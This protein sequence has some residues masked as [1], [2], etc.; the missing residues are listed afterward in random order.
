[1]ANHRGDPTEPLEKREE[2]EER[3]INRFEN[4]ERPP[5]KQWDKDA[6]LPKQRAH[7]GEM[8]LTVLQFLKF[9]TD[10]FNVPH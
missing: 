3:C 10:C 1:M 9:S 7:C 4:V 2:F 8:K 5:I 6:F